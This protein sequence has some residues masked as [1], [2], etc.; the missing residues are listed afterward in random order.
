MQTEGENKEVCQICLEEDVEP[1]VKINVCGHAWHR[2]CL[3]D[4]MRRHPTIH[5]LCPQ[6][7]S[8]CGRLVNPAFPR[9]I[10]EHIALYKQVLEEEKAKM[11]QEESGSSCI[12]S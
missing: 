1:T 7:I 9:T 5:L 6:G 2:R 8:T 12:M 11:E 3:E 4:Y 10:A